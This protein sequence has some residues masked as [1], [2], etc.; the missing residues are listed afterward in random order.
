MLLRQHHLTHLSPCLRYNYCSRDGIQFCDRFFYDARRGNW[1]SNLY[2]H[3]FNLC[4]TANHSGLLYV[5][6]VTQIDMCGNLHM[7]IRFR[8]KKETSPRPAVSPI[9]TVYKISIKKK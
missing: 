8:E 3:D 6:F 2:L 1:I 5:T 9:L 4:H 7:Y